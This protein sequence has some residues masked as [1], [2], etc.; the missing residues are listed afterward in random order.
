MSDY[1]PPEYRWTVRGVEVELVR[2]IRIKAYQQGVDQAVIV[3]EALR[4]YLQ[5]DA[6]RV[7]R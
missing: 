4:E 6:V 1:K 5:R 2:Q 7:P 3:N